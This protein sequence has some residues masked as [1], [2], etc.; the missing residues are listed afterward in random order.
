MSSCGTVSSNHIDR[1]PN[2]LDVALAVLIDEQNVIQWNIHSNGNIVNV[3]MTFATPDLAVAQSP[4]PQ[5]QVN[6]ARNNSRAQQRRDDN[7]A[8]VW[9]QSTPATNCEYYKPSTVTEYNNADIV[10]IV[11]V[12]DISGSNI[13]LS[14]CAPSYVPQS[15]SKLGQTSEVADS[16]VIEHDPKPERETPGHTDPFVDGMKNHIVNKHEHTH[17]WNVRNNKI[18]TDNS[19]DF[20]KVIIDNRSIVRHTT[21]RGLTKCGTIANFETNKHSDFFNVLEK[22]KDNIEYNESLSVINMFSD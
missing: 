11:Q 3:P 16:T 22:D 20:Q 1:L 2:V 18:K 6:S 5:P 9:S 17:K 14:A 10:D 19:E 21:V 12:K 7:W 13:E 8:V 15:V 4:M